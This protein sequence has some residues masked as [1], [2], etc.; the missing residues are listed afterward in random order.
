MQRRI[1]STLRGWPSVCRRSRCQK[2]THLKQEMR[3]ISFLMHSRRS[4]PLMQVSESAHRPSILIDDGFEL[5]QMQNGGTK[6]QHRT[7]REGWDSSRR[8]KDHHNIG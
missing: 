6:G 3:L 2:E 1:G 8:Q 4:G 5:L 7:V